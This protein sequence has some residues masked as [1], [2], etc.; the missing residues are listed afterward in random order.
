MSGVTVAVWPSR[1][2][3]FIRGVRPLILVLLVPGAHA[4]VIDGARWHR[5]IR[6]LAPA[7]CS[8]AVGWTRAST[9]PD[10][11]VST[12]DEGPVFLYTGRRTIPVRTFPV[13]Q[14][15]G[16]PTPEQARAG[17]VLLPATH[18]ARAVLVS[19]RLARDAARYLAGSPAPRLAA[20]GEYAGGA[21]CIVL[22]T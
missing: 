7:S 21:A 8:F 3:R 20:R 4:A 15:P 10:D 13:D 16:S 14:Y 19:T 18:P 12:E 6:V 9:A 2:S 5:A 11:I 1:P 22:P 17:L